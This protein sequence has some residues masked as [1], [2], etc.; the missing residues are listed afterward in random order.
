MPNEDKREDEGPS[1]IFFIES[2]DYI[3]EEEDVLSSLSNDLRN[4]NIKEPK[5]LGYIDIK[6]SSASARAF[7][8]EPDSN[9]SSN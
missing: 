6:I 2:G 7:S 5:T 3:E 9:I 4:L 1:E 8:H